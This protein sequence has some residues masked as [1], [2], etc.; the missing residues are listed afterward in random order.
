MS[1]NRLRL[2]SNA[3]FVYISASGCVLSV[4]AHRWLTDF[5]RHLFSLAHSS[6]YPEY[7]WDRFSCCN[8]LWCYLIASRT[9]KDDYFPTRV[10]QLSR[11]Q[12][13]TFLLSFCSC[14]ISCSP[15]SPFL[16]VLQILSKETITVSSCVLLFSLHYLRVSLSL[17]LRQP[18]NHLFAITDISC[19]LPAL[20]I[21]HTDRLPHAQAS[22]LPLSLSVYSFLCKFVCL[23]S[24]NTYF[25]YITV[26]L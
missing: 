14:S 4:H 24:S 17:S 11:L 21:G 18:S 7:L 1:R 23:W 9:L 16:F 8:C 20:Q 26:D 25:I 3:L 12:C 10:C 19:F 22:P 13:V 6:L 2:P 5:E 15:W